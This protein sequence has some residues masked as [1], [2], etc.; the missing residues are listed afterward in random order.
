M[1]T[2]YS[3]IGDLF[4]YISKNKSRRHNNNHHHHHR[5]RRRRRHRRE[6]IE[7]TLEIGSHVRSV[8][9]R[10]ELP[11][12]YTRNYYNAGFGSQFYMYRYWEW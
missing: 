4:S 5:R 12:R 1:R 10:R 3:N 6:G 2:I 11:T 8:E 7:I 9:G